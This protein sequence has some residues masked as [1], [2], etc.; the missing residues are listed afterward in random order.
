MKKICPALWESR[1]VLKFQATWKQTRL[2]SV[3]LI[4]CP[5]FCHIFMDN[6]R[7][8]TWKS[9][10]AFWSL[11]RPSFE[12]PNKYLF[13][14]PAHTGVARIW[15]LWAKG[16]VKRSLFSKLEGWIS[17]RD[18]SGPNAS[19]S[20]FSENPEKSSSSFSEEERHELGNANSSLSSFSFLLLSISCMQWFPS[21]L[22]IPVTTQGA[23]S[24]PIPSM[25]G[26]SALHDTRVSRGLRRGSI[27]FYL[28]LHDGKHGE[29][30]APVLS[31]H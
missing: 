8:N 2:S 15:L 9:L 6:Q 17:F 1:R 7:R 22:S 5:L 25:Y 26:M 13:F 29:K 18:F 31:R 16:S 10:L 14:L 11:A 4:R 19:R 27:S 23:Y 20:R 28:G 30:P 3:W 12:S 24:Y 21:N